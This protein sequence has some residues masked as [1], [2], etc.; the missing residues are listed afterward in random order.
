MDKPL[1][2][3]ENISTGYGVIPVLH[4][5]NLSVYTGDIY[6]LLGPNGGGKSTILKVCSRQIDPCQVQSKL[7]EEPWRAYHQKN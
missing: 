3:L 4:E 7:P 1:L 6:A 5:I 2:E